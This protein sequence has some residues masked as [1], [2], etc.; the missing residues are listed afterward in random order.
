MSSQLLASTFHAQFCFPHNTLPRPDVLIAG[1]AD[2]GGG[3]IL[4]T[5][6]K[7]FPTPV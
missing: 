7:T 3:H 5:Y 2:H 1:D 6:Q 4:D